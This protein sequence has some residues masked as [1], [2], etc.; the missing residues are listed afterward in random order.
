MA[1]IVFL[2]NMN[3]FVQRLFLPTH[4]PICKFPKKKKPF[5]FVS[6]QDVS[7]TELR[8]L[9][10]PFGEIIDIDIKKQGV[11]SAYSFVQYA[12]IRSVVSAMDK[13]D[14]QHI[15][16]N[17]IKVSDGGGGGRNEGRGQSKG[18]VHTLHR[19]WGVINK[20]QNSWPWLRATVFRAGWPVRRPS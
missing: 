12:D 20:E 19:Q 17:R 9:F 10:E 6:D 18:R 11:V 1:E 16:T 5:A 3:I 14:G 4:F 13:M 2:W 7:M 8:K 15:G